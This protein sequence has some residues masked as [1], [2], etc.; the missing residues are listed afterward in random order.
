MAA[1]MAILSI[2]LSIFVHASAWGQSVLYVDAS[3][4]GGDGSSWGQAFNDL[5]TALAAAG[6]SGGVVNE[7]RVATGTYRPA[8]P[9][10]SRNASFQLISGVSLKGGY[11][12]IVSGTPDDR[13]ID[14][15][16]TIL[17]GDLNG[18]DVG[19]SNRGD[20]S[21][22]VVSGNGTNSTAQLDGFAI[23]GGKADGPGFPI[24]DTRGGGMRIAG[25]GA[26]TVL[27]CDFTSNE[28]E[29]GGAVSLSGG[30]SPSFTGCT[31][32]GNV[33]VGTGM[34]GAV[35][36][37]DSSAV[38]SEC[39]FSSNSAIGTGGAIHI[40][41]SSVAGMSNCGFTQNTS[42]GLGGG[43]MLSDGSMTLTNCA[44]TENQAGHS[45]GGL[46]C[47]GDNLILNSCRFIANS[48]QHGGGG[49]SG[50]GSQLTADSCV[51]L[52][53]HCDSFSG[54]GG[55]GC[56]WS[57]NGPSLMTNCVF[58]GN[59]SS[60][61]GG[62]FATDVT[63]SNA[64]LLHCVFFGNSSQQAGGGVY[65]GNE[66][67]LRIYNSILW[68]NSDS[69]GDPTSSQVY[70]ALTTVS[71]SYNCIQGMPS[72][73]LGTGNIDLDPLFVD[74]DGPDDVAG[75][76]D[77]DLHLQGMSPCINRGIDSALSAPTTD[78]EGDPRLQHCRVDM[79]AD[80][81]AYFSDCNI[82]SISDVC[83]EMGGLSGDCDHDGILDV[84]EV[85]SGATDCDENGVPDDC[86]FHVGAL[87]LPGGSVH[88]PINGHDY[89]VSPTVTD[90]PA[91]E[92]FAASL[93]GHLA[94]V[95]DAA[96]NAWIVQT[97]EPLYSDTRLFIG[98]ND[99]HVEGTFVWSDGT[100]VDYVN[101]GSGQPDN[102]TGNG[103][104]AGQQWGDIALRNSSPVLAG[105]WSDGSAGLR[106]LI[107]FAPT[108]DCNSNGILDAC[109]IGSGTSLDCNGD[110]IPDECSPDCN[111]NGN[112]D[113]CDIYSGSSND[114]D[115]NLVPD[116][117]EVP[118]LGMG[119]DCDENGVPDACDPDVN[120]NG[121][122]DACEMFQSVL[123]VDS[124][125]AGAGNGLN[126]GDAFTD[127]QS[128]LA[129]ARA[130]SGVVEQIWVAEGAFSPSHCQ[131]GECNAA[132]GKRSISFD[133]V[134]GVALYGGFPA[135]GGSGV[136]GDRDPAI[137]ASVLS[138][139]LSGNDTADPATL[140]ENSLH[141]VRADGVGAGTLLDG[142]TVRAGNADRID[143]ADREGG[144]LSMSNSTLTVRACTFLENHAVHRGGAAR[145]SDGTVL[146][147]QCNFVNNF[148]EAAGAVYDD[149][150]TSTFTECSF[151]QNTAM[152]GSGGALQCTIESTTTL[153]DCQF[154]GNA[155][156]PGDGGAV[157]SEGVVT[158]RRSRFHGNHAQN[159]GAVRI[160][161][162]IESSTFTGNSADSI[163]G[164]I[165]NHGILRIFQSTIAANHADLSGGGIY[166]NGG[167]LYLKN[168]I[169][170]GNTDA[171]SD[172]EAAQLYLTAAPDAL[173][174]F[175]CVQGWTGSWDGENVVPGDPLFVDVDG[176][177]AQI[178][179]LDDD[180]H[181]G[182]GS[183]CIDQGTSFSGLPAQDF[184]G[185]DRVQNCRPDI[186]V[187]ESGNYADC[188]G[189]STAD[190]CDIE[191]LTS[192]DCNTNGVPD[193][194]ESLSGDCNTNGVADE[195]DTYVL[196]RYFDAQSPFGYPAGQSFEFAAAVLPSSDVQ[197]TAH[198]KIALA[199]Y[200][201]NVRLNGIFAGSMV[202]PG[203]SGN[204]SFPRAQTVSIGRDLW[205]QAA[206]LNG[207]DVQIELTPKSTV[208]ECQKSY[209]R[210][211]VEYVVNDCNDNGL[212]DDCDIASL[213]SVD[214]NSNGRPD[215]CERDCNSNG[216]PDECDLLGGSATDCNSNGIL[217]ECELAV[218]TV[219]TDN[220]ADAM[221][222]TSGVQ[223]ACD[224]TGLNE[225]GVTICGNSS[226]SAWYRYIPQTSGNAV[227]SLCDSPGTINNL[228]SVYSGCPGDLTNQVACS[229]GTCGFAGR[230]ATLSVDVVAGR[231]YLLRIAGQTGVS[232]MTIDGPEGFTADC[233]QND[234][235]D[236]CDTA[237]ND[238]NSN[239]VPDNCEVLA[240]DCNTNGMP[241]ECDAVG[242]FSM[243]CNANRLPDECETDCNTNG[244][245]DDCDVAMGTSGDCDA[246]VVPDECQPDCDSDKIADACEIISGSDSDCNENEIPDSCELSGCPV[247]D[248][249]C[250]DC[251][252]NGILD[253]C[254]IS[255]SSPLIAPIDRFV[256]HGDVWGVD[257]ADVNSD[258][259]EDILALTGNEV[260]ILRGDGTG[261]FDPP[262]HHAT[263]GSPR[264]FVVKD[265]D[266]DGDF[267]IVTAGFSTS[268]VVFLRNNGS[269]GFV[270][271]SVTYPT[272]NTPS[273]VVA[274]DF[275]LD[276][277]SDLATTNLASDNVTILLNDGNGAFAGLLPVSMNSAFTPE[278][279]EAADLDGN[280][281]P[282]LVVANASP[283]KT[284][285]LL[286]V[287]MDQ[288][289]QWAGF[290]AGTDYAT[291]FGPVCLDIAD[292][293]L[294]NDMDIVIGGNNRIALLRNQGNGVFG[295]PN[296]I[297]VSSD[298][299]DVELRDLNGDTLPEVFVGYNYNSWFSVI[300]NL[301]GGALGSPASQDLGV[302][303]RKVVTGLLNGDEL[304]DVVTSQFTLR[305][306]RPLVNNGAG[307]FGTVLPTLP[308]NSQPSSILSAD[309]D[310]DGAEDVAIANRG[311]NEV[312][313]LLSN[314]DGT[315][316]NPANYPCGSG[317][318]RIVSGDLNLDGFA[319][320]VVCNGPWD[321]FNTISV[322]LNLGDG[323]FGVATPYS[324]SLALTDV[325][326]GDVNGDAE[327]DLIAT[328]W[329]G[330]AYL[331]LGT[332]GGTL[333][334][335]M[336][337]TGGT[338]LD[339]VE[340]ADLNGD[341][342]LD[343][344]V[345]DYQA[346]FARVKFNLGMDG[347]GQWSSF[348]SWNNLTVGSRPRAVRTVDLN[349]DGHLDIAVV[350]SLEHT[351]SAL[352]GNGDG[353]FSSKVTSPLAGGSH[354]LD[355]A[356]LEIDQNGLPDVVIPLSNSDTAVLMANR[357]NFVFE[358]LGAFA[359]GDN[360]A[361]VCSIELNCDLRRD[362]VFANTSSNNIT[363]WLNESTPPVTT[364]LNHNQ[365]PDVCEIDI[366]QLDSFVHAV[367]SPET[368]SCQVYADWNG[369]KVVDG[370]DVKVF[371]AALIASP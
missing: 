242:G 143:Q 145:G 140:I 217:D 291:S 278:A 121:I 266:G 329:S 33:Q 132:S 52:G 27:N 356:F 338:I 70:S 83:D 280:G 125:A 63:I 88:N 351:F 148:A 304:L 251:N 228:V 275:D 224:T 334:L 65:K 240:E 282:D 300:P 314:R 154:L 16:P 74:A 41:G 350:N 276:G 23:T 139:D 348:G 36:I 58:S 203:T 233:N 364:D 99:M 316:R 10:G 198:G 69:T 358:G 146:F 82:N 347:M 245:P 38:F 344:I 136:F 86:E 173:F 24:F 9:G 283:Q 243:D 118:P 292:I 102:N 112:S 341:S 285:V 309:L 330:I 207:G 248:P 219:A 133:L 247:G 289:S 161:G 128:A 277:D 239:G 336:P 175:C 169:V 96:E 15:Y 50:S 209:L 196:R 25:T 30:A 211:T 55:G 225:D 287:G 220:C 111:T 363:L 357:G 312:T 306:V 93:G 8:A 153:E 176:A 171:G 258:G 163:G 32:S 162:L 222:V 297:P 197:L 91:A 331:L 303:A 14:A 238:C 232:H 116:E 137:H 28:A 165:R 261:R 210:I 79:G 168:S 120:T 272:G 215:E 230:M 250:M 81:T 192:S 183:S 254:D 170:W 190:A 326:I 6:S 11:A 332:G 75:T 73:I 172:V 195:C 72:T 147:D 302:T 352:P 127:L 131:P 359:T 1:R 288:S 12:G 323:T 87:S 241:D 20:N 159:A 129:Y 80:E 281:F 362:A 342:L 368:A 78:Y 199:N 237:G 337:I 54:N 263:S 274:A 45:G 325:A 130:S 235:P 178:G 119:P 229:S 256:V 328:S 158:I 135:G 206:G 349:L 39:E 151:Q 367:L 360:P 113:V 44:F 354:P 37:L 142:F 313:V 48:A 259:H 339:S 213:T 179:T 181:L 205:V 307:G 167:T 105:Q 267:D 185:D 293:D 194:C 157:N 134:D 155:S 57:D 66:G 188:N 320:L 260:A 204:C 273:C 244:M 164:A 236:D 100:P 324:V 295:D 22:H 294:D 189:N 227:I 177:D 21:Y 76:N 18:D 290:D 166:S 149:G 77:D 49:L 109:D 182:A 85:N 321:D 221:L 298:V 369:D 115:G 98:L 101:W 262:V 310:R 62:G 186:G 174:Q 89:F 216:V 299:T 35:L 126:W 246:N 138:G 94:T 271:G 31:Y 343:L 187:D 231:P 68:N 150:S 19:F 59:T 191:N 26:P 29:Q 106:G 104:W 268:R 270:A 4:P 223:Y 13:D 47:S 284:I 3:A 95:D 90:W 64:T 51:F 2:S 202:F 264:S 226:P 255:T 335:P 286:N 249:S 53:N 317:P 370:R 84:C 46:R 308:M 160:A 355:F 305:T 71:A 141:V 301:G 92:A 61:E 340:L 296:N 201:L 97:F 208:G 234:L 366:S 114:C 34:G 42:G 212:P 17:S 253:G 60:G 361:T 117:C 5:Q 214:C 311:N 122:V 327:A 265:F 110:G 322:L 43:V 7:I 103:N 319:D 318:T 107:E 252:Q 353:T 257:L 193:E 156:G 346:G 365:I 184:D 56:N 200:T 108:N 40:Q 124:S 371:V 218:L 180:V 123:Y 269:G 315:F 152:G 67:F 144:G 333:G 279:L 345:A